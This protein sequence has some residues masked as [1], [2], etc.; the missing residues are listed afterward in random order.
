VP[1]IADDNR[2]NRRKPGKARPETLALADE[3]GRAARTEIDTVK[4]GIAV[5]AH[6]II[7]ARARR[8]RIGG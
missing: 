1:N 5:A 7:L 8:E 4:R 2:F 3:W 6:A